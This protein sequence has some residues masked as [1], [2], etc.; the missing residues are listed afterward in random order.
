MH[1]DSLTG[2]APVEGTNEYTKGKEFYGTSSNLSLLNQLINK[3]RSRMS[4]GSPTTHYARSKSDSQKCQLPGQ[5]EFTARTSDAIDGVDQRE[6]LLNDS[7][8]S[9]VNLL[10]ADDIPIR[11]SGVTSGAT[12]P[13]ASIHVSSVEDLNKMPTQPSL[14][15][16]SPDT[17]VASRIRSTDHTE[18]ASSAQSDS[19]DSAATSLARAH[20]IELQLEKEYIRIF[21]DNLHY[22][23]PFLSHTAFIARCERDL[24]N[25]KS[26]QNARRQAS[27]F[28]A[29]Y[30][31]VTAV[32]AITAGRD[33]LDT[34]RSTLGRRPSSQDSRAEP[35]VPTSIDLSKIYFARA[36][37][38]LGDYFEICSLE[39][40]QTLVLMSLY[41]QNALKPHACYMYSGM[42]V[43]SALAIGMPDE[44]KPELPVEYDETKRTWWAVYAQEVDMSCSSG[45]RSSLVDP[46]SYRLPFPVGNTDSGSSPIEMIPQ[47]A[48]FA[49]ILLQISLQLYHRPRN[50]SEHE[51]SSIAFSLDAELLAWK[52][53]LPCWLNCDSHSFTEPEWAGKQRLVLQLRFYN[54]KILVHRPMITNPGTQS[55]QESHTEA[56]LDGA[57][58]TIELLYEAF[59]HRHYFR[60]WYYNATYT[61]YASM[62]VLYVILIDYPHVSKCEL[63]Q[64]VEKSLEILHAMNNVKVARRCADLI[65]EVL[66]VAKDQQATSQAA[67]DGNG[68][69]SSLTVNT[70]SKLDIAHQAF[71]RSDA[72]NEQSA[73]VILDHISNDFWATLVDPVTLEGFATDANTGQ[74][75]NFDG[76]WNAI[77]SDLWMNFN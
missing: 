23:H 33:A 18:L 22:I 34:L 4:L 35:S 77:D 52:S 73:N 75:L 30:N 40:V 20:W 71:A 48:L 29:L 58:K 12:T 55:L 28:L 24:W 15:L 16:Q 13:V 61:L 44:C 19:H 1:E 39:G 11:E 76:G 68:Q 21:F 74:M 31:A 7:R 26:L 5:E 3:A 2:L 41:A 14:Q 67:S 66:E 47:M 9:L 57:R 72:L 65:L 32:G 60:T 17:D 59:M 6:N 38:A 53:N 45:R 64:D 10:S 37:K 70:L 42:A 63:I 8:I 49:A 69:R 56:C 46:N 54:A 27:H 36:K 50:I 43:R 25:G 62:L 51:R